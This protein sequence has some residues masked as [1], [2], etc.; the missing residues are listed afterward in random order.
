M[1]RS[2]IDGGTVLVTGASSG[3]GMEIARQLGPRAKT[4]VLVARRVERLEE[5]KKELVSANGAL[6]VEVLPCDLSK[7]DEVEKLV[8]EVGGRGLEVDVLV[9]NAGVGMMGV[10][11]KADAER[12]AFMIDLNV[13]SLSLLTLSLLPGMVER[14]RG[15]I[16]NVS[17]GF[18]LAFL[19]LFAAYCGTKH[20][21]TGFTEALRADLE[22]TG[23]TATQVCPGPVATEF[24][25][26]MGNF[27]GAK[28]PGWVEI[29]AADCA[30]AS[31]RAFDARRAM[32]VPGLVMKLVMLV[33]A[34][35]PRFMRRLFARAVGRLARRRQLAAASL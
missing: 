3:I 28:V 20:Y 18:G 27:T 6:R 15:G 12:T 17:S 5:L 33:N 25:Q 22:G 26:T 11:D 21:V 7:R 10:F 30:R 31:L 34:L 14:G 2:A 32:V 9:N 19:P 8:A 4:L 24:E 23:V 13:T 1:G 35:S 29:S 16:L